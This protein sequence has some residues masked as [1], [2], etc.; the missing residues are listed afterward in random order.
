MT[1]AVKDPRSEVSVEQALEA[2][3]HLFSSQGFR[4]TSMRQIAAESGL[5]VGNLYHHFANK[6][7]I[8]QRLIDQYWEL[9]TDP[10]H[11]L[12]R[13]LAAGG[14]P[15]DLEEM[16]AAIEEVVEDFRPY[17]LLIY[18]DVIE[19]E[20]RHIHSFYEGMAGRFEAVYA[21]RFRERQ[22]AGDFGD[23]D[24]MVAVMVATRWFFYFFTVEKCFGV[25]MHFG[26]SPEKATTEFIRLLRYGLLPRPGGEHV[27]DAAAPLPG[28]AGEEAQ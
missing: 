27:N 18:V 9:V 4:A 28:S 20:G 13:V 1:T 7:E 23:V 15:E 19:F 6:E 21:D 16:A 26:M 12:T 25:P 2:A 14:F 5:S 24:P 22:A 3:L 8:F 17:I 10:E 11:P